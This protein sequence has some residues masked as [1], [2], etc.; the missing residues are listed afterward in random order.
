MSILCS[1]SIHSEVVTAGVATLFAPRCPVVI[2]GT[3]G[4]RYTNV[5][6]PSNVTR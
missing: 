5:I 2:F 6:F 3:H 1:E 4:M